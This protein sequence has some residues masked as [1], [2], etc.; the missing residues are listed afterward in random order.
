MTLTESDAIKLI[1][2]MNRMDQEIINSPDRKKYIDINTPW[3]DADEINSALDT[4]MNKRK[5]HRKATKIEANS[6]FKKNTTNYVGKTETINKET[7]EIINNKKVVKVK[8]EDPLIKH[9][10][11]DHLDRNMA[12][13]SS[14]LKTKKRHRESKPVLRSILKK[15][16]TE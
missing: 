1:E 16:N 10:L 4:L 7:E 8:F 6:F 9:P 15:K 13:P 11:A 12:S 14:L 3:K 2:M 5:E